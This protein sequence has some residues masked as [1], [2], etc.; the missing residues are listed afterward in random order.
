MGAWCHGPVLWGLFL[1]GD[2]DS[3]GVGGAI[4]ESLKMTARFSPNAIVSTSK[5]AVSTTLRATD[6]YCK[7]IALFISVW[8]ACN[9]R[10]VEIVSQAP[11][12]FVDC[13][14]PSSVC[15]ET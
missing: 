9:R 15:A 8:L 11:I 5:I 6:E 12:L 2:V 13:R 14:A 4:A 10:A 3:V 7:P 1:S